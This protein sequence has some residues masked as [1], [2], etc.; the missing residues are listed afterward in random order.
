MPRES[1][2]SGC[3]RLFAPKFWEV[4]GTYKW[5][6]CHPIDA[7]WDMGILKGGGDTQT[8]PPVMN[9]F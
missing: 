8:L 4:V 2:L 5:Y 1:H 3:F 7:D 9:L 6:F